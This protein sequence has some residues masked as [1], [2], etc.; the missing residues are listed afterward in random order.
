MADAVE[1]R[2]SLVFLLCCHDG[3]E[4]EGEG[5]GEDEDVYLARVAIGGRSAEGR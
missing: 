4:G 2:S 1:F 3:G 5:E